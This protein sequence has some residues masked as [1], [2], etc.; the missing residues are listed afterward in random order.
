[1]HDGITLKKI[2]KIGQKFT[3]LPISLDYLIMNP[4]KTA[5]ITNT[6]I[7]FNLTYLEGQ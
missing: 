1:M 5:T 6:K 4:Q 7:E 2:Q 3:F